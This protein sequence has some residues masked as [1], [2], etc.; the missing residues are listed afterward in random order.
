MSRFMTAMLAASANNPELLAPARKNLPQLLE[1]LLAEGPNGLRQV[2]L[3]PAVHGLL[4]WEHMGV[5][6]AADPLR[7]TMIDELLSLA[8][9]SATSISS[10]PKA[11]GRKGV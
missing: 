6:S 5:L 1:P 2:A 3:W 10:A 8:E 7:Q 4:L 11:K 9:G